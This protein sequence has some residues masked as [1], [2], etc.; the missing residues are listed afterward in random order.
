MM[1]DLSRNNAVTDPAQIY[2][3]PGPAQFTLTTRTTQRNTLKL[4][5]EIK[6]GIVSRHRHIDRQ[7]KS[8]DKCKQKNK[9]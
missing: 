1:L 6:T 4:S 7:K 3:L 2:V 8:T 9:I 5:K